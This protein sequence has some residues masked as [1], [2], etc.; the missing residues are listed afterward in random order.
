MY[1]LGDDDTRHK[2]NAVRTI[3]ETMMGKK[4]LVLLVFEM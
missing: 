3:F 1:T 4:G 2:N